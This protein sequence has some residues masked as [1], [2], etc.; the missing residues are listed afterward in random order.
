MPPS[1]RGRKGGSLLILLPLASPLT[2]TP[3]PQCHNKME[4]GGKK[5]S[6]G[7]TTDRGKA[8][9][10]EAGALLLGSDE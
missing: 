2:P 1:N 9:A 7:N 10:A 8:S 6:V 3:T 5:S 4:E